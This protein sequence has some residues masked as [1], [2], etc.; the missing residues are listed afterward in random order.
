MSRLFERRATLTI[1][2]LLVKCGGD[3]LRLQFVIEQSIDS[4]L[5][6]A[7]ATIW[8]LN[9]HSRGRI[10]NL[11]K[12]QFI[13]TAGYGDNQGSVF[14]GEAVHIVSKH[15]PVGWSTKITAADGYTAS[16]S[17]VNIALAPGATVSQLISHIAQAMSLPSGRAVASA[18]ELDTLGTFFG[19]AI[20]INGTAKAEL[21]RLARTLG[22]EWSIQHGELQVLPKGR[23]LPDIAVLLSK[24][25]GLID[26]PEMVYDDKGKKKKHYLRVKALLQAGLT[27]GKLI[28]LQSVEHKGVFKIQKAKHSGDTWGDEYFSELEVVA[29]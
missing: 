10:A 23:A 12:P 7:E 18:Q 17:F 28:S 14:A 21:D 8:N 13:V 19:C 27:P 15:E 25:T 1:G 26:S 3:G 29:A 16:R 11:S 22:F 24:S 6:K 9:E 20:V 2:D 4:A 5:N